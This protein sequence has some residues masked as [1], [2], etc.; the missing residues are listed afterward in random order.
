MGEFWQGLKGK[1]HA[2][3]WNRHKE[4]QAFQLYVQSCSDNVKS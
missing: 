2:S 3:L 4:W 1:D